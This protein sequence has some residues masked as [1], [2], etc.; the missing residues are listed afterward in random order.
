[1]DNDIVTRLRKNHCCDNT[2]CRQA[3]LAA[4]EIERL[5]AEIDEWRNVFWDLTKNG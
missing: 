2:D 4:D 5:R 1:M 3:E